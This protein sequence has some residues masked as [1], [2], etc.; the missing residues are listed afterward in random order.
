MKVVVVTTMV[1]FQRGDVDTVADTLVAELRAAGHQAELLRVPFT[2]DRSEAIAGQLLLAGSLQ[3]P[4][5][6]RIITLT[7]P[8]SLVPHPA[9]TVWL[10]EDLA[11]EITDDAMR[12]L[13]DTAAEKSLSDARCLFTASATVAERL[14]RS[15]ALDAELLQVPREPSEHP[16]GGSGQGHGVDWPTTIQALLS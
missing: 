8:A 5:A 15:D 7:V 2:L 12:L 1:P 14:E 6:D 9:K 4:E 13:L 11:T 3:L 16:A 10:I